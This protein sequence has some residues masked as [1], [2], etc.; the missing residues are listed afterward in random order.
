MARKKEQGKPD[1]SNQENGRK[2]GDVGPGRPPVEHQFQPGN[3]G[4][5]GRPKGSKSLKK[6]INDRLHENDGELANLIVDKLVR[7][8]KWGNY[9]TIK[10]MIDLSD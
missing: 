5:P 2:T 1:P 6:L 10:M 8:I 4:G 7:E 9:R 3:P